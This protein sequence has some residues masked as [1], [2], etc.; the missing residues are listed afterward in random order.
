MFNIF[1]GIS[2]Y[3][4]I[5]KFHPCSHFTTLYPRSSSHFETENNAIAILSVLMISSNINGLFP[6]YSV[7]H[8]YVLHNTV[9]YRCPQ[10][11]Y[12]LLITHRSLLYFGCIKY[13]I[14]VGK[15]MLVYT[16]TDKH[17]HVLTCPGEPSVN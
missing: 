6:S 16:P 14:N 5:Q 12:L 8:Q 7:R 9:K 4:N 17:E 1:L 10:V 3:T 11:T 2:Y 15:R 13:E